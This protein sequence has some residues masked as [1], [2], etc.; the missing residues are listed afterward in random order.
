[1]SFK[2]KKYEILPHISDLKIRIFGRTKENIFQNA[3]FAM[4][5]NMKPEVSKKNTE[6]KVKIKSLDSATLLADFLNETLYL[7]QVKKEAY[8]NLKISK[9]TDTEL[10]GE[11]AGEKVKRFGEDIKA[12]TYHDLEV[13]QVADGWEAVIVFDI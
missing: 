4:S 10:E 13:K 7:S 2:E 11:I 12:V 8:F 5:E 6:R 9:L 1:M 3:L